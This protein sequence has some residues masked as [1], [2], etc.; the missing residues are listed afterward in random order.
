M[1]PASSGKTILIVEDEYLVAKELREIVRETGATALGPFA[2][3]AP[4]QQAA[5]TSNI[6]GAILDVTLG[7][8]TVFPLADELLARGVPF[9]LQTGYGTTMLPERFRAVARIEKPFD[10]AEM[11]NLVGAMLQPRIEAEA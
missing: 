1:S 5:R 4:A 6:S 9:I 8:E 2:R 10:L 7:L 11:R 3:L